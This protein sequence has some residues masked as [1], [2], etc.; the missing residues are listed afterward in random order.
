MSEMQLDAFA[1]SE[2]LQ[3]LL[4]DLNSLSIEQRN[5]VIKRVPAMLQS[6]IALF[7]SELKNRNVKD[8]GDLAQ[9]LVIAL[10]HYLGGLQT[11]IPRNTRLEKE[12]RNIRIYKAHNGSNI[13]QLAM[14]HGLTSIQI[15][16]IISEQLAAEKARRQLKLF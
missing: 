9:R 14:E 10:A 7:E 5:D 1:E 8:S 3:H 6:M 12:L 15:Y 11:Y 13:A 4:T 2:D 16:K